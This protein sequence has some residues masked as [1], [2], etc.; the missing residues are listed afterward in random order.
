MTE[1]VLTFCTAEL[2]PEVISHF[3]HLSQRTEESSKIWSI[4]RT[5]SETPIGKRTRT[6][7]RAFQT[8]FLNAPLSTLTTFVRSA[9]QSNSYHFSR[10]TFAVLDKRSRDDETVVLWTRIERIGGELMERG[11]GDGDGDGDGGAEWEGDEQVVSV[12]W[13]DFRVEFC[14][15]CWVVGLLQMRPRLF[16]EIV[17]KGQGAQVDGEGVLRVDAPMK[18]GDVEEGDD[19]FSDEEEE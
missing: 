4:V 17:E 14:K 16:V 5:P 6:P 1:N 18:K 8:G 7:I 15:A 9:P 19:D 3:I 12:E 11:D 13:R 2:P 10:N